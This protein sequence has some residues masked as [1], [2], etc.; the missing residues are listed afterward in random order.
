MP[1]LT[2]IILAFSIFGSKIPLFGKIS[3][4]NQNFLFKMKL[5]VLANSNTLNL[6]VKFSRP[7]LDQKH[8]FRTICF[9]KVKNIC[10]KWKL[11]PWLIRLR[12]FFSDIY[13]SPFGLE[14]FFWNNCYLKS[15]KDLFKMRAA[16]FISSNILSSVVMFICLALDGK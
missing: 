4:K 10:L 3:P 9:Q 11:V 5:G 1:R 15:Q 7:L 14:I 6:M 16:T 12:C 8:P 13:L 2:W